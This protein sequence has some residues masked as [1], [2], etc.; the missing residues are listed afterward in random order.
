MAVKETLEDTGTCSVDKAESVAEARVILA[1]NRYDAII[2]D[3]AMPETDGIRFLQIVR[4][5]YGDIPFILYTGVE[6]EEVLI[7]AINTGVTY[8]LRKGHEAGPQ[9]AELIYVIEQAVLRRKTEE[10]LRES[11]RRF[12]SIIENIVDV[13]FRTDAAGTILFVS[14]SALPLL[15]GDSVHRIC[16]RNAKEFWD[17]EAGQARMMD[18]LRS[19]GMIS[20]YELVI[21]APDGRSI[22]VSVSCRL[23]YDETGRFAGVEGTFRDISERKHAE[24]ELRQ[25]NSDL[26]QANE[27]LSAT[28]RELEAAQT[29]LRL[30][31]RQLNLLSSITRHDILN[32]ITV[33]TGFLTLLRDEAS[34]MVRTEYLD[35]L[36]DTARMIRSQIAFTRIYQDLGTQEP[37]WIPLSSLVTTLPVPETVTLV[38]ETGE[39]E[40]QAD[41]VI[42][43]VFENLL[44]NT[45]RHG[46]Q[47]TR[48]RIAA[49]PDPAGLVITWEDDGVGIPDGEKYLIFERGFGKNTGL[50]LFL[51]RDI[52]SITGITIQETGTPG[53]GARFEMIV[54]EGAFRTQIV[55]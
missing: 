27:R 18:L 42:G 48:I 17:D 15:G 11:E 4:E 54:P 23:Y 34:E 5:E 25:R 22:P 9:F 46:Q 49:R 6:R 13:F 50:G 26:I 21:S 16:G 52:L 40:I 14:P 29:A 24:Q 47:V 32:K 1:E 3:Y 12:R 19:Q 53:K 41:P 31:N 33:L 10:A 39:F 8:Y 51:A 20:D 30:A 2:A 35:I 7:E 55:A 45:I 37:Q 38:D 44:D 36:E 43:K 28:L